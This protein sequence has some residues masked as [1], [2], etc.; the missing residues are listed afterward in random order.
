MSHVAMTDWTTSEGSPFPLGASWVEKD[1][2]WNFA[3]YSEG[4]EGV[5]LLLYAEADLVNPVFILPLRLPPQQVRTDLA[6]PGAPSLL[7]G[8]RYYA[9]SVVGPEPQGGLRVARL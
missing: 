4:A 9:Y 2:A 3:L 8:A 5:A 7:R 1:S 6:L